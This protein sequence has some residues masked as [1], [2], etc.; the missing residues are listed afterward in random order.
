MDHNPAM[1]G[2]R[3]PRSRSPPETMTDD[4]MPMK[5]QGHMMSATDPDNPQNWF[6]FKKIYVSAVATM[7]AWIV[8]VLE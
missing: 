5:P 7:F 8:Y 4:T 2:A 1:S 3:G 6:A